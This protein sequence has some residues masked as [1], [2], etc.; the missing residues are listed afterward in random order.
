MGIPSGRDAVFAF[1]FDGVICDSARENALS[2]WRALKT[3]WPEKV[4]GDAPQALVETY[5][6]CRPAIETGYQNIPLMLQLLDGATPHDILTR[7]DELVEQIM[8]RENLTNPDL[9]RMFGEARDGWLGEDYDGWIEAQG[10]YPGLVEMVNQ[11]AADAVIITTKQHRF[12]LE[13]VARAGINIEPDCVFGLERHGK[14]GKRSVLQDLREA[15]PQGAIH[16][17][18]DR[19]LTL[20]KMVDLENTR[21]YLVDWGYNTPD[22]RAQ[23][24]DAAS[25]E[26]IDMAAFG[27]VVGASL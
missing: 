20:E 9:E 7:F 15:N 16:F 23:G 24:R 5:V 22:E 26:L 4:T 17:F 21:L 6:S 12:A 1:D 14:G 25:I 2:T 18:E 10:F 27:R 19:L 3:H 8:V 11:V 13:L